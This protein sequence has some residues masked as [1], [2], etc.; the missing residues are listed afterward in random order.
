[1]F[2]SYG[3]KFQRTSRER[4]QE[5]AKP[6]CREPYKVENT[7]N[8]EN[9]SFK[10]STAHKMTL[11]EFRSIKVRQLRATCYKEDGRIKRILTKATKLE[12]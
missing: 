1:M 3:A 10:C 2:V 9:L 5:P 12:F 6:K 4:S 11:R 7:V 8:T